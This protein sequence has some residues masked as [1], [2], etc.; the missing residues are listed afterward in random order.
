MKYASMVIAFA[1]GILFTLT[2]VAFARQQE[3]GYVVERE[4]DIAIEQP[5]PHKGG[6][7]TTSYPF[8]SKDP[9]L[10]V[11]FRKRVLRPGSA[12]GYHLQKENEIY[13]ILQGNGAMQMN[14]KTF[15]VKAG[16][17]ILTKPGSSHGLRPTGDDS[18][19]VMINYILP[20]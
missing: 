4:Q 15:A 16:D 13:Y 11:A 12:I 10:K 7:L 9:D 20:E 3:K 1:L 18:L 5:G 19:T 2:L 6:G 14:G 17:A 8:F